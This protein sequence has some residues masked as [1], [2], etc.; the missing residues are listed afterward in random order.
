MSVHRTVMEGTKWTQCPTEPRIQPQLTL[1]PSLPLVEAVLVA[2]GSCAFQYVHSL[3]R[4]RAEYFCFYLFTALG[5]ESESR[6]V[7]SDSL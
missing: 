7:V 5:L 3:P 4:C 2:D 6:S 1:L